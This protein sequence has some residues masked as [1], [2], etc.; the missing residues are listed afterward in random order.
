MNNTLEARIKEA[1]D[2]WATSCAVGATEAEKAFK[3]CR[4]YSKDFGPAYNNAK[5]ESDKLWYEFWELLQE[6]QEMAIKIYWKISAKETGRWASFHKRGW[7]M[8]YL[9]ASGNQPV[10]QIIC[11]DSYSLGKAKDGDHEPLKVMVADYSVDPAS[12]GR[13]KWRTFKGECAT[14]EEAKEKVQRILQQYPQFL[15]KK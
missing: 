9:D 10:V 15:P 2:K 6:K 13:F 8:G 14:F 12:E 1:G 7:P 5:L 4:S 11:N 3:N